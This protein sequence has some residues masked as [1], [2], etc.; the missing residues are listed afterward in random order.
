MIRRLQKQEELQAAAWLLRYTPIAG[1]LKWSAWILSA[2]A[3]VTSVAIASILPSQTIIDGT[4]GIETNAAEV[5]D[6]AAAGTRALAMPVAADAETDVFREPAAHASSIEASWRIPD[7]LRLALR[8][9]PPRMFAKV[10]DRTP[11][12]PMIRSITL[13]PP[14]AAS[15]PGKLEVRVASTGG[16][17]E[18]SLHD[19]AREAGL[20]EPLMRQLTEIFG[21]DIDF[22][23][24]VQ[25]GDTFRVF[26]EEKYWLGRK[27]GQG[28]ILAA[29]FLNRG[30]LYR[31]IGFRSKNGTINYYA[32]SGRNLKRTFLRAPVKSTSVSSSFSSR[33]YHP[34]LKLWRAHNGVDYAAPE[35]ASVYATASG[36]VVSASWSGGYGNV[37]VIDHGSGYSTLYAHLSRHRKH[38]KI[39]Q[40]VEQGEV[41]GFVGKSG[42]ATGPHLHYE[43]QVNGE[44][45][46][47]LTFQLPEGSPIGETDRSNFTRVAQEWIAQLDLLDSR[48]LAAR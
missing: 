34:I 19:A 33:R 13:S 39:G 30:R 8:A 26:Y 18:R 20:S 21:W 45:K 37:V 10:S 29:E 41:I 5:F 9:G 17:I 4:A 24:D 28:P 40:Q 6:R 36:R 15:G 35:G 12:S 16:F 27:I 47:P 31:A 48:R 25:P 22:A 23:L 7:E 14:Y 42:L 3:V 38:L 32:P 43:F 11:E 46:N 44:H 1:S 2:G